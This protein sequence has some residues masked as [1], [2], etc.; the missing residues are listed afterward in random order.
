MKLRN[1]IVWTHRWLALTAGAFW[2]VASLTGGI[3]VFERE[4]D[5]WLNRDRFASTEGAAPPGALDRTLA[6]LSATGAVRSVAWLH[7]EHVLRVAVEDAGG[8]RPVFLDGGTGRVIESTRPRRDY[9]AG[10]GSLHVTLLA[11]RPGYLLVRLASAAAVLSMLTGLYLWWPGLR[12]FARGF[13]VRLRRGFY[14]LNFDLHQALGAITFVL[15]FV[16]TATGAFMGIPGAIDRAARALLP[17]DPPPPAAAPWED[18]AMTDA[19]ASIEALAAAAEAASGGAIA[20]VTFAASGAGPVEAAVRKPGEAVE[21][22]VLLAPGDARVLDVIDGSRR[23][24]E[25]RFG[26]ALGRLHRGWFTG[27]AGRIVV[28]AACIAGGFLA[29]SGFLV[30]WMKRS[31]KLESA[32]RR[33]LA[34]A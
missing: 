12:T 28:S 25:Q 14:A 19:H 31:R 2:A 16:M 9:A 17:P 33:D 4:I 7:E 24:R 15:L 13:A 10:I 3:L 1:T 8:R 29:L 30:W 32:R 26:A 34:P 23:P 11:G 22:R 18:E 20:S 6:E 21:T 5:Q 27:L